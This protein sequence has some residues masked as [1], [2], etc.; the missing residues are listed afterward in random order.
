MLA[1]RLKKLGAFALRNVDALLVIAVALG[2]LVAEIV[3]S[4]SRELVDA[5]IL[6]LLGVTA[7]VLLRDRGQHHDLGQVQQLAG[8]AISDRPYEV[9]WQKRHWDITDRDSATIKITEQLRFTRNDVATI[10]HWSRGDGEDRRNHARWRRSKETPWLAAR[11]IYEF[12]V[13][14]GKKV[15][16]CFDEEHKRG[17]MLEWS[18]ERDAEGRFPTGH[19]A[20]EL[21]ARTK[22][23]HPRVMRITWPADAPPTHI[24]I[25]HGD[26]PARTL[27]AR[28][29][30]GRAYVEEKIAGLAVGEAVEIAWTW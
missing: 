2:V 8:D 6:A 19:E 30:D 18:I 9:V 7:V 27:S 24:E 17:D 26:R 21:Q 3:G 10:A 13:R 11:K 1:G 23:D 29:K 22:S 15:I 16:Y 4:P 25:R 28:Q 14:G 5:A 20:V 12:P